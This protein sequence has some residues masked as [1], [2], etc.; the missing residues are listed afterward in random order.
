M[1]GDFWAGACMFAFTVTA[2][3]LVL[4]WAGVL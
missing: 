3:L 2:C 4:H 1:M